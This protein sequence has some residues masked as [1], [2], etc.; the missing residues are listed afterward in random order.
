MIVSIVELNGGLGN[1]MFIYAFYYALSK[2]ASFWLTEID[3]EASYTHHNGY[4]LSSIFK[5]IPPIKKK[6][7]RRIK[8]VHT[9]YLTKYIFRTVKE[10]KSG[11][12]Q[13]VY[14]HCFPFIVYKGFWQSEL[15]FKE[16]T[17]DIRNIFQFQ[18]DYLNTKTKII[19]DT[20]TNCQSVSVHIRKGDYSFNEELNGACTLEY[21]I[22]AIKIVEKKLENPVYFVFSDDLEWVKNNF[23]FINYYLIDWNKDTDSWQDMFLMSTC[24][25]NIIAN[26]TFS[27]WGAWLNKY[28]QKIVIAPKRWFKTWD[29]KDIVPQNWIKI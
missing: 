14:S 2:K 25:H 19:F 20:I 16:Y 5:K 27:W 24:K 1:Q 29:A 15:Y 8:K 17:S 6:Y 22:N 7:Q 18:F 21:Y 28:E 12:F 9:T 3:V 23:V 11:I 10:N 13:A 4:E 26:S